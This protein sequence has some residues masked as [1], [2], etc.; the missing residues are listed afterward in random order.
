MALGTNPN[1]VSADAGYRDEKNLAHLARRRIAAYLAPGR[2]R[3]SQTHAAGPRRWPKGSRK[4]VMARKLKLAGRRSRYR[5]RKQ[6]VEPLFGHIKHARGFRQ[7]LLRGLDKIRAEWAKI[8]T[9][10]NLLELAKATA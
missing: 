4:A 7:F 3:H 9:V 6:I 10:H 1:E 2:A 8:C 5:P